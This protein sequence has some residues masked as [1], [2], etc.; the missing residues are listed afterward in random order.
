MEL[1][2]KNQPVSLPQIEIEIELDEEIEV[3]SDLLVGA[4]EENTESAYSEL[5]LSPLKPAKDDKLIVMHEDTSFITPTAK[6]PSIASIQPA[7]D[8]IKPKISAK[9]VSLI[10]ELVQQIVD[11]VNIL[12][13]DGRTETTLT[14]KHPP[15][16]AGSQVTI[17]EFDT[18]KKEFNIKFENLSQEAHELISMQSNLDRLQSGLQ[19]KG[20]NVHI[21]TANTEIEQPQHV[22]KGYN[23][24]HGSDSRQEQHQHSDQQQEEQES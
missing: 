10:E 2:R 12:K 5:D 1:K 16:F 23:D 7:T 14:L 17:T 3:E 9:T 24:R 22:F 18:A 20:Y 4:F 6:S 21:V 8:G 13:V 11:E 15:M 19:Q